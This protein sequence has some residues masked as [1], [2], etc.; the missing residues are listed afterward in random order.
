MQPRIALL[1]FIL[2]VSCLTNVAT[3]RAQGAPQRLRPDEYAT[4]ALIYNQELSAL[5]T[6]ALYPICI[7]VAAWMPTKPLLQYLRNGGFEVSYPTLCEPAR[8]R[9]G[10][11]HPK[12]YPH[13]LRISIDKLHRDPEGRISMHVA[14]D[15]LTLRP[16]EHIG[17]TL[18]RGIYLFKQTEEG[19]WQITSYTKEYDFKDEKQQS[20]NCDCSAQA[21]RK[22]N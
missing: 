5:G 3:A 19:E 15:D 22:L 17:A 7:D 20:T 10:Q 11:H 4:V 1:V 14:S 21:P 9:G 2:T 18:R 6:G 16:G 8:A 13:G 12:D